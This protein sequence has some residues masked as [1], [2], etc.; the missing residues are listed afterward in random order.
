M[1]GKHGI[2]ANHCISTPT[3]KQLRS[4]YLGDTHCLQV[5]E[6]ILARVTLTAKSGSRWRFR[7]ECLGP[8]TEILVDGTAIAMIQG[9][10][11][12]L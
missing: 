5:G 8:N 4:T 6:S 2:T 10:A 1:L 9:H 11:S 12:E 3:Q 7:T